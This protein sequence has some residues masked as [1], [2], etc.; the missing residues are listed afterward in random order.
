M[1][2]S[3]FEELKICFLELPHALSLIERYKG[4]PVGDIDYISI[5]T[6]DYYFILNERSYPLGTKNGRVCFCGFGVKQSESPKPINGPEDLISRIVWK[7]TR[8]TRHLFPFLR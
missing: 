4:I 8:D 3:R 1:Y 7:S 2:L 6:E 5:P